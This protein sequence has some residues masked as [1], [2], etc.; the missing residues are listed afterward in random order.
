M[1]LIETSILTIRCNKMKFIFSLS[2]NKK[3]KIEKIENKKTSY[4]DLQHAEMEK[5]E[6]EKWINSL[7]HSPFK[8]VELRRKVRERREEE[9]ESIDKWYLLDTSLCD[10]HFP[11]A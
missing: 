2:R 7:T 10:I 1:L 11:L 6:R 5:S 4:L 9:K 8:I 3:E